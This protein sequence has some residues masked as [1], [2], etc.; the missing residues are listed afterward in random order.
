ML[1]DKIIFNKR[2]DLEKLGKLDIKSDGIELNV[3]QVL[4]L[5][6]SLRD[7]ST[8]RRVELIKAVFGYY[9]K[10]CPETVSFEEVKNSETLQNPIPP[11]NIYQN[12][13]GI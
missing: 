6:I 13:Y 5:T 2:A 1:R 4:Y 9:E 7:V 11:R 12:K 8:E 10:V 3:D